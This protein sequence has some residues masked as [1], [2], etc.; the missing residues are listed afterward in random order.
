MLT[1]SFDGGQR[2]KFQRFRQRVD[3]AELA[4]ILVPRGLLVALVSQ[5]DAYVGALIRQL[6]RLKSEI[7]DTSGKTLTCSQLTEFESIESAREYVFE[8]E[9]ESVL[10][11]SHAE[12]FGWLEAKFNLPLKKGLPAWPV[13]RGSRTKEPFCPLQLESYRAIP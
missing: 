3:R 6:F 12:Q 11:E 4:Q 13:C 10:R 7:L 1:Y 9:I 5:F 8:K 2:L